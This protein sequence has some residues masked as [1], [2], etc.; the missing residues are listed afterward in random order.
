MAKVLQ[1]VHE[2]GWIHRDLHPGNWMIV[3]GKLM[4]IDY[5]LACNLGEG[6]YTKGGF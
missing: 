6:G 1:Y 4:L 3:D 5:G 2:Q